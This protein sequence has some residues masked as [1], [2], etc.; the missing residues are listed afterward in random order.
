[1]APRARRLLGQEEYLVASIDD[2]ITM[3]TAA[4]RPKDIG[5]VELLRIAADEVSR[6][7]E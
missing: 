5:Q 3:K 7:D 6:R 1:L 4:G 2:L